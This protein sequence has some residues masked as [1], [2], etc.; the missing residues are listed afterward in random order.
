MLI[1]MKRNGMTHRHWLQVAI[2]FCGGR[3]NL[4]QLI[5]VDTPRITDWL[6]HGNTISLENAIKIEYAT[7]G[8]VNRLQLT[9]HLD[10]KLRNQIKAE[11]EAAQNARPPLG[12]K[13]RVTLG[14][15]IETALGVRKGVRSD[16]L[17]R[18]KFPKV[19]DNGD[20]FFSSQQLH[21]GR[22]AEI[23]NHYAR[24]GS[25]KSYQKAKKIVQLGVP[26]LIDAMDHDFPIDRAV[27]IVQYPPERQRYLLSLSDKQMIRELRAASNEKSG[28]KKALPKE[29]SK[30]HPEIIPKRSTNTTEEKNIPEIN[31]TEKSGSHFSG[32]S[33]TMAWALLSFVGLLKFEI[34]RSDCREQNQNRKTRIIS[35]RAT[36]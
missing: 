34:K 11:Y 6:N 9:P 15:A 8:A 31:M 22:T 26:E 13:Q 20:D 7:Q 23:A 12:F 3:G 18:E 25:Y 19:E 17:L 24:L 2:N 1:M 30:D 10:K 33:P 4:A 29:N 28:S 32:Y 5:G 14:L 27:K 21:K 36:V 16:R 35:A